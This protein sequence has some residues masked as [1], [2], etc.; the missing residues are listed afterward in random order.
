MQRS[1][2]LRSRREDRPRPPAVPSNR[3]EAAREHEARR[4]VSLDRM[5][6]VPGPR[7]DTHVHRSR[8]ATQRH[9]RQHEH[10]GTWRG[11]LRA[12]L[13]V[14]LMPLSALG[15]FDAQLMRSYLSVLNR[16][17]R[18][19]MPFPCGYHVRSAPRSLVPGSV[20][21]GGSDSN[22]LGAQSLVLASRAMGALI[23][24]RMPAN[25]IRKHAAAAPSAAGTP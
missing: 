6:L 10:G 8:S 20:D 7:Q 1:T 9:L 21:L 17:A 4:H 18:R 14:R 5:Q 3:P 19:P 23:L 25:R 16:Q 24:Q 2:T 15:S 12:D 11:C 22:V 13:P